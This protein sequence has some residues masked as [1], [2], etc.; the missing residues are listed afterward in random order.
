MLGMNETGEMEKIYGIFNRFVGEDSREHILIK[1]YLLSVSRNDNKK[2]PD[3]ITDYAKEQ[4]NNPIELIRIIESSVKAIGEINDLRNKESE[5]YR[6]KRGID[7][8]HQ[9]DF[10]KLIEENVMSNSIL[11]TKLD[12]LD[13]QEEIIKTMSVSQTD[14]QTKIRNLENTVSDLNNQ[15]SSM[16]DIV[17]KTVEK[18]NMISEITA[19]TAKDNENFKG[20]IKILTKLL[21]KAIMK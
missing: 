16:V 18:L 20:Q 1:E 11:I 12:Q 4:L 14:I 8:T 10:N 15:L 21:S 13:K 17:N 5:F 3:F 19:N 9:I 7:H 2:F 6:A